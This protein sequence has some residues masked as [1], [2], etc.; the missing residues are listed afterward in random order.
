[1][2]HRRSQSLDSPNDFVTGYERIAGEAPVI[3]DEMNVAMA[4]SA[5]TDLDA[6]IMGTEGLFLVSVR[7]QR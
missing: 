3:I 5:V 4:Y 6:D 1:M 7:N 2:A